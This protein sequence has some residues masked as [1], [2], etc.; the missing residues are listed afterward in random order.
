MGTPKASES[1]KE[2]RTCLKFGLTPKPSLIL[3]QI[4]LW[5]KP[6]ETAVYGF[7]VFIP[8]SYC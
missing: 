6:Y 7:N 2:I 8:N 4:N 5:E 1:Q 3:D